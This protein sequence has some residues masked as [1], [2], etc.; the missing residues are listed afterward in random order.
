MPDT[1][2]QC[3]VCSKKFGGNTAQDRYKAHCKIEHIEFYRANI[4][5][6]KDPKQINRDAY[7]KRKRTHPE[8]VETQRIMARMRKKARS[9]QIEVLERCRSPEP[10]RHP[11][12]ETIDPNNPYYIATRLGHFVGITL[13]DLKDF[14]VQATLER[15]ISNSGYSHPVEVKNALALLQETKHD[16]L[17]S[18]YHEYRRV[19]IDK[20]DYPARLEHYQRMVELVEHK[21]LAP[22]TYVDEAKVNTR[23]QE[24]YEKH[25][26]DVQRKK[27][28][29]QYSNLLAATDA[30]GA[31]EGTGVDVD[32]EED[33][34]DGEGEEDAEGEEEE[35]DTAEEDEVVVVAGGGE[36]E[37]EM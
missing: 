28:R 15:A 7:L 22:A 18:C 10:I 12:A 11:R 26:H 9:E 20:E 29:Q 30:T 33:H 25:L 6:L 37:Q 8:A 21:R 32:G 19:C 36:N 27:L 16:I 1:V 4:R 3:G 14:P 34:E 5:P 17:A 35:V 31:S 24:L 2:V 23:A 13:Q